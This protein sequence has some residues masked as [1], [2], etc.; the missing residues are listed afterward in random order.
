MY[1][2][3]FE[4]H[5]AKTADCRLDKDGAPKFNGATPCISHKHCN[6][7]QHACLAWAAS[8]LRPLSGTN[9]IVQG[10]A[11]STYSSMHACVAANPPDGGMHNATTPLCQAQPGL[12]QQSQ[13]LMTSVSSTHHFALESE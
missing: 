11:S 4:D 6:M 1:G 2:D 7:W 8:P 12:F 10:S 13:G 3:F 5:E 9:S